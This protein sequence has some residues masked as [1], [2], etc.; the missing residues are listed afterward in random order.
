MDT[1]SLIALANAH[2]AGTAKTGTERATLRLVTNFTDMLLGKCL[3]G[4]SISQG[5]SPTLEDTPYRQYHF[6]LADQQS[7]LMRSNADI[8]YFIFDISPYAQ[9]EFVADATHFETVISGIETYAQN[10]KS[11]VVVMTFPLPYD[12]AYGNLF[13][14]NPLWKQICTANESLSRLAAKYA[15][16]SL[17]DSN[18]LISRIGR[19]HARSPRDACAFDVP[20]TPE[21]TATLAEECIAEL[22]S[23]RGRAKKCIVVDLDNTLWGG[24]VGEVGTQGVALGSGY[25]GLAFQEF[26]RLLKRYR[27]RG[28]ILA[29]A[30]R[31][32]EADVDAVFAENTNMVLTKDDFAA[33]RVN[34]LPKS[35]NIRSLAKELNIGVDSMIFL[36]DDGANR[37]EVSNALPGIV[38]PELPAEPERY[39]DMLITST[40][41]TQRTLTAEDRTKA[42]MYTAERKRKEVTH[43][44]SPE[45]YLATLGI[46]ITISVNDE[47]QIPRL[48][49]LTQK[50]NQFNLTTRRYTEADLK[51]MILDGARIY[52]ASVRDRFG[53]YGVTMLA[54]VT[55]AN[56]TPVIDTL[57]MS[58]R[59]MGRSVE[60]TLLDRLATDAHKAGSS[61]LDAAFIKTAKNMPA[62]PF[63]RDA[64]FSAYGDTYRLDLERFA[65]AKPAAIARALEYITIAP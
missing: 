32:N 61:T 16:L 12:T 3:V 1:L 42:D 37:A 28:V 34:W 56:D 23:S 4:L 35:E 51:H 52:A 62:E 58:C 60:F 20:F 31:N 26:Q 41:F 36:D 55:G 57:L 2:Y 19:T 18:R 13:E 33:V 21:F 29:I 27:E 39:G 50:T 59:V 22:L 30:S 64:G 43:G 45:Q 24:I 17:I 47:A 65:K 54:I 8:T 53:S 44:A 49:Q 46:E 15:N 38:V 5:I 7:A 6:E 11:S 10:T 14:L 40:Y 9:T 63:L 48:A 25:P